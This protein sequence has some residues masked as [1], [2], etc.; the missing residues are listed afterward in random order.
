MHGDV[1]IKIAVVVV[2]DKSDA[3]A[4]FFPANANLFGDVFKSSGPIVVE[5]MDSVGKTDSQIGVAV[6]IE[7][8]GGAAEAAAG[9]FEA[10]FLRDVRKFSV[11]EVAEQVARAIG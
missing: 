1:E 9:D 11:P 6:V 3:D 5:E 10:G 8:A 2:I 7:I 4:A